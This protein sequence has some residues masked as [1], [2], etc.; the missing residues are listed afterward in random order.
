MLV[1]GFYYEG[2]HPHGK[3]VRERRKGAFLSH[4]QSAF[5]QN[6]NVEAEEVMQA[7]CQLLAA[8]LTAG[9]VEKVKSTLPGEIRSL[10]PDR[11]RVLSL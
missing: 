4:V 8:H 7:V 9:E 11:V 3:P 6:G 1:R 10:W 5:R 2:W